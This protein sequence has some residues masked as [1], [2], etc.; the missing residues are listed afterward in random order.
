[1]KKEKGEKIK[2]IK[3]QKINF[4]VTNPFKII[5]FVSGLANCYL[6]LQKCAFSFLFLASALLIVS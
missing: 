3:C 6:P 1:M 4:K 2:E 5:H